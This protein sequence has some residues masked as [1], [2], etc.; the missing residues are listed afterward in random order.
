M[1]AKVRRTL[2]FPA[3][4][5]RRLRS[6]SN[7]RRMTD[8]QL[9]VEAV[10]AYLAGLDSKILYQRLDRQDRKMRTLV[11]D[12]EMTLEMLATFVWFWFAH[13]PELPA[14]SKKAAGIDAN[15]RSDRFFTTI[16]ER[17]SSSSRWRKLLADGMR[18]HD[19]AA[20]EDTLSSSEES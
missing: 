5:D 20:D 15:S 1:S 7:D 14:G 17:L 6:A 10:S 12:Q 13:H 2:R 4:F 3:E 18:K 19:F 8:S 16:A 11:R 9:V